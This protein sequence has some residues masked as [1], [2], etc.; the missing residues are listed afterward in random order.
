MDDQAVIDDVGTSLR[1]G[2]RILWRRLR[3]V[4]SCHCFAISIV[5]VA[6]WARSYSSMFLLKVA[7]S[8]VRLF[9][10]NSWEGRVTMNLRRSRTRV[11]DGFLVYGYS[12]PERLLAVHNV[13]RSLIVD[14]YSPFGVGRSAR[15]RVWEVI[16][17]HWVMAATTLLMA[18]LLRP[19]PR[20]SYGLRELLITVSI[21]SLV[22][23]SIEAATRI[24]S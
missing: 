10:A 22:L 9:A 19:K 6:L 17:P 11:K 12:H 24:R 20:F 15:G 14:P 13:Q 23:G 1:K 5:V 4:L 8:P 2:Q 21:V 7:V 18:V 3:V 16:I